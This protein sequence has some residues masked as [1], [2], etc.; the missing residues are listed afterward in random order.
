[1]ATQRTARDRRSTWEHLGPPAHGTHRGVT[2]RMR[3][4]GRVRGSPPEMPTAGAV[5]TGSSGSHPTEFLEQEMLVLEPVR[6]PG[7]R[8]ARPDSKRTGTRG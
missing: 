7:P 4:T 5:D 2:S 8:D 6:G 1:M 3:H